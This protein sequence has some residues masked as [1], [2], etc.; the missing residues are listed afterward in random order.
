MP[1]KLTQEVFNKL[2]RAGL[3]EGTQDYEDFAI[4]KNIVFKNG[5]LSQDVYERRIQAICEYI[6]GKRLYKTLDL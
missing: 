1:D 4:A 6:H 3:E 5:Y 2:T